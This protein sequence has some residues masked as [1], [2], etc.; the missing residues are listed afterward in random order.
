M[1]ISKAPWKIVYEDKN[2]APLKDANG[3]TINR[4]YI[5]TKEHIAN[6]TL[7]VNAPE[8]LDACKSVICSPIMPYFISLI[9][10]PSLSINALIVYAI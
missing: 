8:L 3:K 7:I 10:S 9:I 5:D 4:L 6:A 2:T 1:K